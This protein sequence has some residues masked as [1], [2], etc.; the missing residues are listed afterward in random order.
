MFRW[1]LLDKAHLNIN[2]MPIHILDAGTQRHD[3]LAIVM[4]ITLIP[5]LGLSS[6]LKLMN[7]LFADMQVNQ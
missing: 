4:L 5:K 1:A 6:W 2:G 3:M 7:E